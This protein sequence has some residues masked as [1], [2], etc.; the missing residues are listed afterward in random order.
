MIVQVMAAVPQGKLE[1]K[2]SGDWRDCGLLFASC[3]QRE[4]NWHI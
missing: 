4:P 2:D 3:K 1:E